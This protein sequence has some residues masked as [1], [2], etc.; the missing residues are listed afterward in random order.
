MTGMITMLK[1]REH[2]DEDDALK[3]ITG[4]GK[5]V[6]IL[7][8]EQMDKDV[9]KRGQN[10]LAFW[11]QNY[12][13]VT[14]SGGEVPVNPKTFKNDTV[15]ISSKDNVLTY[16][17]HLGYLGYNEEDGTAFIPNEEIR[18][19]MGYAVES[20]PWKEMIAFMEESEKMLEATLNMDSSTV[21]EEMEK[22]HD[23]NVPSVKYNNENSLSSVLSLA[24]LSAREYYFKPVREL[25]AGKGFADVVYAPKPKFVGEYPALVVELK[26]NKDAESAI[27][28]IKEK[29]YPDSIKEYTD[30]ILLV[31]I[32]YDKKTKKHEC[33]IEKL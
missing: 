4:T 2:E 26:W 25:P 14:I 28:Q 8:K 31:G 5:P 16:L 13:A 1:G 22:I 6:L 17:I 27:T 7:C 3:L 32:N 19:E 10:W 20:N 21:A 9:S 24:Y 12:L 18:E 15:S 23:E 29:R 11:R 33:I 30:N